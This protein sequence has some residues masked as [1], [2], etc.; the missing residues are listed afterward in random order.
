MQ[1]LIQ[2]EISVRQLLSLSHFTDDETETQTG[3][4][5]SLRPHDQ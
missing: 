5:T 4:V 1:H 3:K 2:A